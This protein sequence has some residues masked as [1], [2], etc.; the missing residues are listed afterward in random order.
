VTLLASPRLTSKHAMLLSNALFL[1]SSDPCSS[2]SSLLPLIQPTMKATF[3]SKASFIGI[4]RSRC[5]FDCE[6]RAPRNIPNE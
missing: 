2:L 6:P 3:R 5:L 4:E 1:I